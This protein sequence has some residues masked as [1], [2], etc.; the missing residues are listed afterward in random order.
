MSSNVPQN[1]SSSNWPNSYPAGQDCY[2]IIHS[3]GGKEFDIILSQGETEADFDFIEV[4]LHWFLL[5]FACIWACARVLDHTV[6]KIIL[7]WVN[8]ILHGEAKLSSLV[9]FV[10]NL[11]QKTLFS[12]NQIK[13]ESN[14]FKR[15]F[16]KVRSWLRQE[17]VSQFWGSSKSLF[18]TWV[19]FSEALYFKW[20]NKTRFVTKLIWLRH[21]TI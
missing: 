3:N 12:L 14:V 20:R 16:P 2:W 6:Y 11:F 7:Q 18:Q 4:K 5:V 21:F 17:D 10:I 1:F 9:F 15:I 8:P 19:I 13:F